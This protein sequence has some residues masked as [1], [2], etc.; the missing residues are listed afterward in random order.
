MKT[1]IKRH[2]IWQILRL[3]VIG[4]GPIP[5]S[6]PGRPIGRAVNQKPVINF[7]RL[8]L[9]VLS[10]IAVDSYFEKY[11]HTSNDSCVN[12]SKLDIPPMVSVIIMARSR[13]YATMTDNHEVSKAS[14][15]LSA[16]S[17]AFTQLNRHCRER[18]L[19]YLVYQLTFNQPKWFESTYPQGCFRCRLYPIHSNEAVL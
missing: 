12:F 16:I 15:K 4:S 3:F 6:F 9:L 8:L 13:P 17:S 5:G 1:E 10:S 18:L 2:C 7:I 19:R 11:N 14:Q